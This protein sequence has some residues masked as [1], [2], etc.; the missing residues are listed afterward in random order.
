MTLTVLVRTR[1]PGTKVRASVRS[2]YEGWSQLTIVTYKHVNAEV[3]LKR[4]C[5]I[6][7]MIQ[8]CKGSTIQH[9][10]F[11]LETSSESC[12]CI[13]DSPSSASNMRRQTGRLYTYS[14]SQ[15]P[16]QVV[17]VHLKHGNK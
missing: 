2:T 3:V 12:H 14:A 11:M 7:V 9:D 17:V 1:M 5:Y 10:G 4:Y 8:L 16:S 13:V 15:L 6:A